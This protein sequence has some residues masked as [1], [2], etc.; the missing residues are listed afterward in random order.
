MKKKVERQ[1]ATGDDMRVR[2]AILLSCL[3]LCACSIIPDDG[4]SSRSI[5]ATQT[6]P[7][8]R[9]GLVDLD[10]AATQQIAA[11]PPQALTG[12]ANISSDARNDLIGPG[13][14]L[15]I[16]LFEATSTG[17]FGRSTDLGTSDHLQSASTA[18]SEETLPHVTVDRN[19][20]ITVPYGGEVNIAGL[21][22]Q[23]A[24][25]A[26]RRSLRSKAI[27][28]QVTLT[29]TDS[30]A[31]SVDIL[32]SVRNSG[33]FMLS[34]YRD[35]LLDM[36]ASAGGPTEQPAD[37]L[38]VISRGRTSAEGV[39]SDIMADPTQNIR[40]APQDE[41]TV[42][43]R[44]RKFST[45]GALGRSDQIAITDSSLTLAGALGKT[46]GL[47]DNSANP[48]AIMVFRFERPEVA[49]ALGITAP[50]TSIGVPIVYRLNL[51]KPESFFVANNFYIKSDD[52]LYV[53]RADLAEAKK[54]LEFVDS[55]TEVNY[56]VY[57]NSVALGRNGAAR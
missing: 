12:L 27:D 5:Q 9:Y 39:L 44:P 33:H 46:G 40:L 36:L 53:A 10:F 48:S 8:V 26:I 23:Q 18:G 7:A 54:F 32:G 25:E 41:I 56:N 6:R 1:H 37:L 47:E 21:T 19:G 35:R 14:K 50:A 2:F 52:L 49:A 55:I 24:E 51:R 42:L 29:V 22:P 43:D 20:A 4:P 30:P 57:A 28:P 3:G 34:P 31:N 38:I 45:F 13:D 15:A 11:H 17:L 16:S